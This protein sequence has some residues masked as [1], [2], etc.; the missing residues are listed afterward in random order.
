[1][2]PQSLKEGILQEL[3]SLPVI[4][5]GVFLYGSQAEGVADE[6]S[7]TDLCLVAGPDLDPAWLQKQ[8]WRHIRADRYDIRIFELLPL[9]MQIRILST[10]ILISSPDLYALSEYLYPWWK[11]WDDQRWYQTPIPGAP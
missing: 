7:D 2:D 5:P 11:K 9:F 4:L 8:A 3:S 6:R 1:M 10:G